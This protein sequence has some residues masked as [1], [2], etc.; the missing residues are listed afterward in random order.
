M[1]RLVAALALASLPL[2]A[3]SD[4]G[5]YDKPSAIALTAGQSKT[6]PSGGAIIQIICDDTSVVEAERSAA[7]VKLTGLKPGQTLCSVLGTN[8][9]RLLYQVTVAAKKP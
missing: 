1:A 6:V 8:Y 7:G 9:V 3:Q 5:A 4:G 2:L